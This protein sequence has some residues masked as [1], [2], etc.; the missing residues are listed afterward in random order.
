M[1]TIMLCV[2]K[3]KL[4]TIPNLITCLNLLMGC[5]AL[6]SAFRGD[7]MCAFWFLVAAAGFDFLDGFFARLLKQYSD[8]GKE[9]DSL[10][11]VV[12]FGVVPAVVMWKMMSLTQCTTCEYMPLLG[13][14]IAP[15]SALRL[16]KFNIDDRQV[17]EFIGLP[18]PANALFITSLPFL[19][20]EI[21]WW[22][23]C[24]L[25]VLMS[26]LLVSEVPMFSLKF[27]GFGFGQ[28]KLRYLFLIFVAV[29]VAVCGVAAVAYVMITYVVVSVVRNMITR[30]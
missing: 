15:M 7:L 26:W 21:P 5:A 13:L 25:T 22:V 8:V 27:K 20:F 1:A 29:V 3:I 17:S 11:D 2:M 30:K 16:A 12:S 18:T 19:G 6:M 9:L 10:A 24:A 14:L 4:F 28:N 23:L